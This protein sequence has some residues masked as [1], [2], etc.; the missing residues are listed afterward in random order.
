MTT[1][2]IAKIDEVLS[3]LKMHSALLV[4]VLFLL[5]FILMVASVCLKLLLDLPGLITPAVFLAF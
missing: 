3:F 4:A 2:T 5:C 1:E